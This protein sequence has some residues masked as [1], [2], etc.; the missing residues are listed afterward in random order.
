MTSAPPV[1]TGADLLAVDGLRR[2]C[3]AVADEAGNRSRP[4]SGVNKKTG[5]GSLQDRQVI[6]GKDLRPCHTEYLLPSASAATSTSCSLR[7]RDF[8]RSWRT[9]PGSAHSC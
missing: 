5:V 8:R 4:R 9:S 2:G 1:T 6:E 3:P 7:T